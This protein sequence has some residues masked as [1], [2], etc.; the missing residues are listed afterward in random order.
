MNCESANNE[1]CAVSNGPFNCILCKFWEPK[2]FFLCY[3]GDCQISFV[4]IFSTK[5]F[6][7]LYLDYYELGET[8]VDKY[9]SS[10]NKAIKQHRFYIKMLKNN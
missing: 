5:H 3:M 4:A 9:I 7:T 6:L 8:K 1:N 2:N 10:Q